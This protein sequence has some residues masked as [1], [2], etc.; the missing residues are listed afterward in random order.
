M[1]T[2][3]QLKNIKINLGSTD[4]C[5]NSSCPITVTLYDAFNSFFSVGAFNLITD[6]TL[7][8]NA[9]TTSPLKIA[10]QSA[11]SGQVLTWNGTT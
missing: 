1:L 3:K 4:K 7:S 2:L 9:S 8:G 10:Q 6:N 11:T 5:G